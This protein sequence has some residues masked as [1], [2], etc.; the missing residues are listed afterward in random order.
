M[1]SVNLLPWRERLWQK[2]CRQTQYLLVTALT[3]PLLTA[4]ILGGYNRQQLFQAESATEQVRQ[5]L[6]TLQ[7]LR[8]QQQSLLRARD[9][10]LETERQRQQVM[11]QYQHW[12]HFW[13]QLP[14]LL[15]EAL[16]LER[17]ER[18]Q[19][20]LRIEGWSDS[21]AAVSELRHRLLAQPLFAAVRQRAIVRQSEGRYRFTLQARLREQPGE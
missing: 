14:A 8:T 19:L 13:Q 17:I 11:R 20:L 16:W 15:P 2:R 3:L 18:Q 21:V 10:L 7:H 6:L 9:R 5:Q 12:Q 4:L 1:L